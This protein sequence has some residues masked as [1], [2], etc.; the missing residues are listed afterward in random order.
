[1][2]YSVI[3]VTKLLLCR[4]LSNGGFEEE[5]TWRRPN[6]GQVKVNVD[7]SCVRSLKDM[8]GDGTIRDH[9]CNWLSVFST[10]FGIGLPIVVELLAMDQGLKLVWNMGFKKVIVENDCLEAIQIILVGV[11]IRIHQIF[12]VISEVRVWLSRD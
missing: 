2:N 11:H 1:M 9:T 5:I 3:Y 4:H 12:S 7:G 8:G 6:E 10:N